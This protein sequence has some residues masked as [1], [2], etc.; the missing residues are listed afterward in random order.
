MPAAVNLRRVAAAWWVPGAQAGELLTGTISCAP[1]AK[2]PRDLDFVIEYE[3]GRSEFSARLHR[4]PTDC[5]ARHVRR[6]VGSVQCLRWM[7]AGRVLA[8]Q[9]RG[10][11]TA[12]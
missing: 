3:V 2:N 8:C 12:P 9:S 10:A 5:C 4:I 7:G 6:V 11:R 1:N